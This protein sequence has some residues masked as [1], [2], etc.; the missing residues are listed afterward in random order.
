MGYKTG[1]DFPVLEMY[2]LGYLSL[3]HPPESCHIQISSHFEERVLI[4]SSSYPEASGKLYNQIC[5]K[6]RP[7]LDRLNFM[8]V[9]LDPIQ[10]HTHTHTTCVRGRVYTFLG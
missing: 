4:L 10:T 2:R 1:R 9:P 8:Y 6:T 7:S 5:N 3:M